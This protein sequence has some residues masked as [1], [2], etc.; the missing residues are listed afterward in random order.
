M[1]QASRACKRRASKESSTEHAHL[2]LANFW[3]ALL[4]M[5][6]TRLC[7]VT[8]DIPIA[9]RHLGG[10]LRVY[11]TLAGGLPATK[12][13]MAFY[14][15]LRL[16]LNVYCTVI[17]LYQ[18]LTVSEKAL[19]LGR[20]MFLTSAGMFVCDPSL[21][22]KKNQID[23]IERECDTSESHR[24]LMFR[25]NSIVESICI[26]PLTLIILL[27]A[28][29]FLWMTG[30]RPVVGGRRMFSERA[31]M[32][33]R[34]PLLFIITPRFV[35]QLS[36]MKPLVLMNAGTFKK[37]V[38]RGD[39]RF[40]FTLFFNS[41]FPQ[42]GV[43]EVPTESRKDTRLSS[44][45]ATSS[46]LDDDSHV[47]IESETSS[48]SSEA[49]SETAAEFQTTSLW[50]FVH[51]GAQLLL[52]AVALMSLC[53]K[54]TALHY[55]SK[56]GV[57]DWTCE[58]ILQ[59]LCFANQIAGVL[60]ADVVE[61][62]KVL[63]FLFTGAKVKWDKDL[64]HDVEGYFSLMSMK[65]VDGSIHDHCAW[66]GIWALILLYNFDADD[67]QRL[68][69]SDKR[70]RV[71]QELVH[72]RVD[73]F[74]AVFSFQGES[75]EDMILHIKDLRRKLHVEIGE[76]YDS[77]GDTSMHLAEKMRRLVEVQAYLAGIEDAHD[78]LEF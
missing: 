2:N 56:V 49:T 15:V 24:Q 71:A 39:S 75:H 51:F 30:E 32:A 62:N 74:N 64:V 35:S 58:E 1:A 72:Q 53:C 59:M 17:E 5:Q 27:G 66:P 12:A 55:V 13:A 73:N 7:K 36:L 67:A 50:F 69:L 41:F 45:K 61:L 46:P 29:R 8:A 68:L 28:I 76:A 65:L 16:A 22:L 40:I 34:R 47:L 26:I 43:N 60:D 37:Y 31:H 4:P 77:E 38:F 11:D 9:T 6:K 33:Y 52:I 10:M 25:V 57:Q 78:D 48:G 19:A 20:D 21:H 54:M 18:S 3:N 42:G 14:Y 23:R 63:L 44:R 70:L